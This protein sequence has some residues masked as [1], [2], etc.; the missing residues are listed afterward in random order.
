MLRP[1][2]VNGRYGDPLL[3]VELAHAREALL[4]DLGDCAALSARELLRVA[5]VFVSHMHMDHFI[6]FDALLRVNVG[7]EKEIVL[8]GPEGIAAAVGH[9]LAG[10]TW[11]LADRYTTDLVFE[12]RELHAPE[13]LRVVR[14]RF[15]T[16]FAAEP[17][18][19]RAAP[20]GLVAD[21]PAFQARAA[22]LAHHG[23][24][25]GFAIEQPVR[26]NVWRNRVEERGLA[27]G[28][29]LKPLKEAVRDGLPDDTSIALPGGGAAPLGELRDLVTS[30]PG[31]KL[32]YVTDLRDTPANRDAMARLCRGADMLFIEASFAA[33]E[34]DHALARA[35]LTTTAA[36]EM[37]RAAGARRV[38]P[39]HFSPRN[40]ADEATLVGQVEAAFRGED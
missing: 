39:F 6:G 21:T 9:R 28:S 24:S 19:A 11:D 22:I 10:Y 5:H 29:W 30:E 18:E 40:A 38:E 27:V 17:A 12:V 36:G 8:V 15:L 33:G 25:L 35:H 37:A 23:P 32:G 26:I 3:Y 14:Y 31:R 34:E 4:F 7:R 16:R 1:T 20:G 2:L 13:A